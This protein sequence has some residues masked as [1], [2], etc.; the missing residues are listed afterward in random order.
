MGFVSP[1]EAAPKARAAALK[2]IGLDD[3]AAET[4]YTLAM[5]R[6]WGDWDWV[7]A[8]PEFKRAIELN[9]SFPDALIYYSHFLMIMGR[10]DEAMP[11][12]KRSLELDP[13]NSL[14]HS[15]YGVLFL[16]LRQWDE[17]IAQARIVLSAAPDDAIANQILWEAFGAKGRHKEALAAARVS[18]R[19]IYDDRDVDE[20]L[21]RGFAEA[22]YE[23]AMRRAAQPLIAHCHKSYVNPTDIASL[24][25]EAR[26][27]SRAVDWL[28]KG[29]E[30]RDQSMPY[31]GWPVFDSL[32][33][34]PRFQALLRRMNLPTK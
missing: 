16:Y 25:V 10:P 27:T 20:A 9:P 29:Y 11:R 4:H 7:G 33:S 1:A 18:M 12:A 26:E 2:A 15:A 23:E 8:E 5:S 30:V 24:Y 32:R 22:G 13:F 17:A 28:E 31:M 14:F 6:A 19:S 21:E 3:T 34:D